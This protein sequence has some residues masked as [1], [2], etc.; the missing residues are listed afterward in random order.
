[1]AETCLEKNAEFTERKLAEVRRALPRKLKGGTYCV[2]AVGSYGRREASSESDIDYYVIYENKSELISPEILKAIETTIKETDIP[3]PAADG[4]FNAAVDIEDILGK[5]GGEEDNNSNLTCRALFLAESTWLFNQ[6][7]YK[8]NK[9][10]LLE[11]YVH[12]GVG[13]GKIPLFLLND[14]IRYYRTMAV[15]FDF[16]IKKG[17]PFGIRNIKL[18]FSRKW[19]YFCALVA[20]AETI[21]FSREEK[22][23]QIAKTLELPPA[24]RIQNIFG[25]KG[26]EAIRLYDSFLSK[27]SDGNVRSELDK[28][29]SRDSEKTKIFSELKN[30]G[31]EFTEQ[32]AKLLLDRY[33]IKG[34]LVRHLLF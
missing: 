7:K 28:V 26:K 15:D 18:I 24:K 21:E 27:I 17:K 31:H 32:L 9:R 14:L 23:G 30:E 4:A 34:V 3:M 5:I 11:R 6:T 10:R 8:H 12:E 19:L 25:D 33:D 2:V 22:I 1:M 29:K 13:K 16:K 20:V